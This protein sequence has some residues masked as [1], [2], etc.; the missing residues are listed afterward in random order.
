MTAIDRRELLQHVFLLAGTAAMPVQGFE[1]LA[2]AAK[3]PQ[4]LDN[5]HFALLS[6]VADTIVP[7]TDTPG[8]VDVGVPKL[9]DGLLRVWASPNRR[10]ELIA[11][12]D[13]IDAMS[14]RDRRKPF[15]Q[16]NAQDRF[17]L[18]SAHDAK[19][20]GGAAAAAAA[21]AP[22]PVKPAPTVADPNY[23]RPKQEPGLAGLMGGGATGYAKLK[24]LI[25]VLYYY[26]EPALTKELVYEHVPGKWEPS[27]PVTPATR[28]QGGVAAI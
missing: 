12:L 6:A 14:M 13:Q 21:T 5:A 19:A 26:S 8:A 27:V 4:L 11:A 1:A 22:S 20:G 17:T 23:G 7:R 28:A 24:E 9:F 16:L 2:A 15:A 18:L 25:V 10:A 3:A